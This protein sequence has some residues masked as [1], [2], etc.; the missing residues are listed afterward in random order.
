VRDEYGTR[1]R[2]VALGGVYRHISKFYV[3]KSDF[4]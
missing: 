1:R 3:V 4:E 2:M